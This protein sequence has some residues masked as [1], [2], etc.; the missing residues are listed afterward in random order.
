MHYTLVKEPLSFGRLFF[1]VPLKTDTN[2]T[3]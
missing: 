2:E 3:R 1:G